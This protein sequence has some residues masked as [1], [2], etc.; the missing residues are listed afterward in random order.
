MTAARQLKDLG[1]DLSGH[2]PIAIPQHFSCVNVNQET[3]AVGR[4][5][6]ERD[7]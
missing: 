7:V 4:D 3:M 6:C 2:L 5:C 1:I